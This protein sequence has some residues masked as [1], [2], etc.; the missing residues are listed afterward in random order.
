MKKRID[1]PA[2]VVRFI[3][4]LPKKKLAVPQRRRDGD[5]GLGTATGGQA[6]GRLVS[7]TASAACQPAGK[8][9]LAACL[10]CLAL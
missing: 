6:A 7:A 5:Q 4:T 8:C 3:Y 9:A 10:S 2:L 1:G